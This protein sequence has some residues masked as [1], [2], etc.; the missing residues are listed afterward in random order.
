MKTIIGYKFKI[1]GDNGDSCEWYR[2][3]HLE[4]PI[5][6]TREAAQ[7]A[8]VLTKKKMLNN[9]RF[10]AH[11]YIE[12]QLDCEIRNGRNVN[13]FFEN[14]Q[15]GKMRRYNEVIKR[16]RL[17]EIVPVFGYNEATDEYNEFNLVH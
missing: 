3:N 9:V 10:E 1:V 17:A 13:T 5:Y 4:S 11:K 15:R 12:M 6:T 14:C 2:E 7:K 16:M 8:I